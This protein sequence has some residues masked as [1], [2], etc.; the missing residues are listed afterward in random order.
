MAVADDIIAVELV[1]CDAE[2]LPRFEA[3]AHIDVR[4]K[5]GLVRQYSLC[6]NPGAHDHYRLGI[7]LHPSSRGGSIA[8]H[9]EF[10]ENSVVEIGVPRNHFPLD[11]TATESLLFGGGIGITPILAMAQSLA[12]RGSAFSLHYCVRDRSRA[13]FFQELTEGSFSDHVHFHFDDGPAEQR[14]DVSGAFGLPSAGRHIYV[15]GP[16]GF[17]DFI[18]DEARRRGWPDS[19]IHSERFD[20]DI[21]RAGESFEFVASSSQQSFIIPSDKTIAEVL[22]AAGLDVSLGCEQ[23]ICGTCLSDVLEGIPDHRDLVQ[24]DDEKSSNARIAL[25]CSRSLSAQIVVDV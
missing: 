9:N 23:G 18:I 6:G 17:I 4:T 12:E 22:V 16:A 14:L 24:T 5:S 7:L 10:V 19:Q 13:A 2:P 25:C 3:G 15:C 1:S 11:A 8:V 21:D 20:A